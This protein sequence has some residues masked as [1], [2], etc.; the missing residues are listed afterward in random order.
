LDLKQKPV[1]D[2]ILLEKELLITE[3]PTG[4]KNFMKDFENISKGKYKEAV[5][6][7]TD[8]P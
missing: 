3:V 1:N 6:P 8:I 4:L 2:D 5:K 7:A